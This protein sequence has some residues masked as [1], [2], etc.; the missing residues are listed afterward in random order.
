MVCPVL[1]S[2][3]RSLG[4]SPGDETFG[5]AEQAL[6]SDLTTG[7]ELDHLAVGEETEFVEEGAEVGVVAGTEEAA[8]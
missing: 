7:E 8:K 4:A 1:V 6:A 5:E 3:V 2:G